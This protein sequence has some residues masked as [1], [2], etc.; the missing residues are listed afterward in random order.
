M[1]KLLPKT[2]FIVTLIFVYHLENYTIN[3]LYLKFCI[4]LKLLN[5]NLNNCLKK[6]SENI[7]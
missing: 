6:E 5:R 2:I 4:I 1:I 7:V 3:I